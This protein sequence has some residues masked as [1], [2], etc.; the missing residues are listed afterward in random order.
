[1]SDTIEPINLL[2][3]NALQKR[4]ITFQEGVV[5]FGPDLKLPKDVE[6]AWKRSDGT[7][8]YTIGALAFFI[9]NRDLKPA[10][11][12]KK[13]QG[14]NYPLLGFADRKVALDYLSGATQDCD[15]IDMGL[16]PQTLIKKSHL[17]HGSKT[18]AIQP[19]K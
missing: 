4:E 15:Q 14:D 9:A 17:R 8:Y 1:M 18:S 6:T 5:C 2:R 16:L 19:L 3:E 7:G 10:E 11:Y 12:L 13:A